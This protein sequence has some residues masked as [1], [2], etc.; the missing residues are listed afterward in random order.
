MSCGCRFVD[1]LVDQDIVELQEW[2]DLN[3]EAATTNRTI[4][5]AS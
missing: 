1:L 2:N 5:Q 3:I 4:A